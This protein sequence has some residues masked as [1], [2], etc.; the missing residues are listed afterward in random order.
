M[1]YAS[2]TRIVHLGTL[3]LPSGSF[4]AFARA[5]VESALSGP[6]EVLCA[7]G[8]PGFLPNTI[9]T[10]QATDTSRIELAQNDEQSITL[11][12]PITLS[13]AATVTFDCNQ[14]GAN[15]GYTGTLDFR[16]IQVSAIKV[17]LVHFP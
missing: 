2:V 17:G 12:G 4:F 14:T 13:S 9:D 11:A 6:Q 3:N 1:N 10:S 8:A 15:M 7:L 5:S 16:G